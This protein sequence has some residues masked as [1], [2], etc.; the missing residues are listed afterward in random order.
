MFDDGDPY[1]ARVRQV[2]LAFPDATEKVAHG[3]PTFRSQ[4]VFV[5][6]GGGTKGSASTRQQ[7]DHS[8]L[9]LPDAG[10][11]PALEEDPHYFLPAYYGPYGWIGW[12]LTCDGAAPDEVDWGEVFELVHASYRGLSSPD[13]VR[14]LDERD[15]TPS[16]FG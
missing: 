5:V 14:R 16:D 2:C 3:R 13:Q 9:L 6:Y 12:N 11:K 4:K 7:Y 8:L 10:E 15:L 1:L